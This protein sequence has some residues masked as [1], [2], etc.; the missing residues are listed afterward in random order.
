MYL[1]VQVQYKLY[2]LALELSFQ[3][4]IMSSTHTIQRP[5]LFFPFGSL[6]TTCMGTFE[7]RHSTIKSPPH[8]GPTRLHWPRD[9]KVDAVLFSR[10]WRIFSPQRSRNLCKA[11]DDEYPYFFSLPP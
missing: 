1:Y 8:M 7:A 11:H 6:D 10:I 5:L 2:V 9:K 3:S 4:L